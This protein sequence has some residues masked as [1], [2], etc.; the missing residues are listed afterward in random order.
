MKEDK[1]YMCGLCER[2]AVKIMS[3]CGEFIARCM[4][5]ELIGEAAET[6]EKALEAHAAAASVEVARDTNERYGEE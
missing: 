1:S 5:C 6:E 2:K 4:S 3:L